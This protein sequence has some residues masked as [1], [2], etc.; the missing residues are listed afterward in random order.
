S[1]IWNVW[2]RH[3][4]C[5]CGSMITTS[6][7]EQS[8]RELT[9]W[10]DPPQ[11]TPVSVETV[12]RPNTTTLYPQVQLSLEPSHTQSSSHHK[13]T[14]F[15]QVVSSISFQSDIWNVW[16]RHQGCSVEVSLRTY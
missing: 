13:E 5:S 16:G 12:H 9:E 3:Q 4:G 11:V 8:V 10:V 2:G 15:I 6:E 7:E 1:D 14:N